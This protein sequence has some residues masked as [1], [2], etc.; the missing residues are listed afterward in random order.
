MLWES[1]SASISSAARREIVGVRGQYLGM[2][3]SQ[4]LLQPG[5]LCLVAA[6]LRQLDVGDHREA[7]GVDVLQAL[8]G[9][10][11]SAREPHQHIRVDQGPGGHLRLVVGVVAVE[12]RGADPAD[13]GA[14]VGHILPITPHAKERIV[15]GGSGGCYIR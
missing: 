11:V 4:P 6:V 10:G 15:T 7:P 2:S 5:E 1:A 12:A 9:A 13:I 8:R 14:H 3:C